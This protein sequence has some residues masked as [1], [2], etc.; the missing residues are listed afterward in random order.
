[1]NNGYEL[2]GALIFGIILGVFVPIL[3]FAFEVERTAVK[4]GHATWVSDEYGNAEF[5][6]AASCIGKGGN[7]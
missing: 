5:R 1:M 6:W 3:F 4:E 7:K 2:L